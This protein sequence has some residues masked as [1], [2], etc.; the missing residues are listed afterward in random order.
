MSDL[1]ISADNLNVEG[2]YQSIRN[3]LNNKKDNELVIDHNFL[4]QNDLNHIKK[5]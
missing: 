1:D 3:K 5:K 4:T 2:I